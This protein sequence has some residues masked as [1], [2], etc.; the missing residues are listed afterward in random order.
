M[1]NMSEMIDTAKKSATK[2]F[3]D[4]SLLLHDPTELRA[5][6]EKDGY[7]FFR[8]LFSTEKLSLLRLQILEILQRWNL[9][10]RSQ[11]LMAGIADVEAVNKLSDESVQGYGFPV[12]LYLEIQQ[13]E[14]FQAVAHDK[15]LLDALRTLFQTE[16]FPHPKTIAR[17]V[18]PH[19]EV[20]AT[21]P[22]QDFLH[23][24]G[25]PVTWTAWFPLGDCPRELGG[26]SMLEGSNHYGVIGV[27]AQKGAG[28]L[29]SILCNL[30]LDWAEGDLK[31]GDVIL[32]SSHTVHKALP[33]S[34]GNQIRL[35]CDFRYQ[36]QHMV[37]DPRS[38]QPHI[39]C[40]WDEIY[41]DWT[42][43]TYKYYW[44]NLDLNFSEWDETI[45]W[46]KEKIC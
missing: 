19:R 23:I 21:P 13:L 32:F 18:L 22:H 42:D 7:L 24:Q 20:H 44:K 17:V 16:P 41:K 33:N 3:Q 9:L 28:G 27:T 14:L 29:E 39:A 10:D 34:M 46:Q 37:I 45:R 25:T 31:L 15:A 40:S 5:R 8:G 4:S 35:S 1:S 2:E 6:A 11:A 43:D 36:P 38:L 26:L 12:E 30:D